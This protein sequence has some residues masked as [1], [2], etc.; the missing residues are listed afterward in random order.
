MLDDALSHGADG[1][2]GL[3]LAEVHSSEALVVVDGPLFGHRLRRRLQHGR[4]TGLQLL[5]LLGGL[6]PDAVQ[7]TGVVVAETGNVDAG[8][9]LWRPLGPL[10]RFGLGLWVSLF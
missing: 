10:L 2:Q 6:E 3:V 8:T 1:L 9:R 5:D 7:P 4:D